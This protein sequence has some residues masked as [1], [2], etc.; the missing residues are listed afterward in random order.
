MKGGSYLPKEVEE[1]QEYEFKYYKLDVSKLVQLMKKDLQ[2]TSE[3]SAFLSQYKKEDIIKYLQSPVTS[4][5]IIRQISR[6]LYNLS[7][8]YKRLI[9]YVSDMARYDYIIN[10]NNNKIIELPKENILKKYL[11]TTKYVEDMN[12]KHEFSKITKTSFVED[13]F[14]GYDYSTNY[15]YFIQPLN[16][17]YCRLNGWADGVR[18]FQFN[19]SFFSNTKNQKLLETYYA[20]EFKEKYDLY[21]E[22][23][24]EYRWQELSVEN[25]VCIKLNE[26]LDYPIPFFASIFPDI[27]DLQDYKLLKKAKEELQNYVVLVAKIPYRKDADKANDFA[28]HLDEAITFGN[29]AMQQL[30]DQVGFILSPYEDIK[31]IHL[32]DKNKIENNPVADAEKSFWNS[33]GVNQ[34]IFNSDK[35]TE[36]SIRKSI[37]SDETII[38]NLYRQYERWLNRK[39]KLSL[40]DNFKVKILNTTEMNYGEVYKRLKE[41]ASYGIPVKRE[42]CGSLGMSPLEVQYST[43]LENDILGLQDKF[44]PLTS[45]NTLS[46]DKK[47]SNRPPRET[48]G[49]SDGEGQENNEE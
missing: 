20:P 12:I 40:D 47:D 25:S 31:D 27:F 22:K 24:Q 11:K 37:V 8:Q 18:T 3:G 49:A 7:P 23:G 48:D 29:R 16:P 33:S 43:T 41:A 2:A 5:K 32:G 38:F 42:V 14:Y 15:S 1:K 34:A 35:I 21:R 36:E 13:V 39:L 9:H 28:L 19:F 30:P 46:P 10:I 26:E 6:L 45:A 44:I 17:D 4:G